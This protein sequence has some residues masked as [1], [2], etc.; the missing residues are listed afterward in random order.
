MSTIRRYKIE[1]KKI[2]QLSFV[3]CNKEVNVVLCSRGKLVYNWRIPVNTETSHFVLYPCWTVSSFIVY[4]LH[5]SYPCM[6]KSL[7]NYNYG[8]DTWRPKLI[9]PSQNDNKIQIH[10]TTQNAYYRHTKSRIKLSSK[11]KLIQRG[12]LMF[13]NRE[14]HLSSESEL[15]MSFQ[16]TLNLPCLY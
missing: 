11:N 13:I 12:I 7:N 3:P 6:S 1:W 4:S 5:L 10:M 2:N 14:D 8:E 16:Q 9:E 15:M